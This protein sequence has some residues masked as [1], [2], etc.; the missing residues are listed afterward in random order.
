M[1]GPRHTRLRERSRVSPVGPHFA[2][3]LP[4]TSAQNSDRHLRRRLN[5][6]ARRRPVPQ[7]L[8]EPPRLRPYPALDQLSVL[9]QDAD[10]AVLRVD[11]NVNMVMVVMATLVTGAFGCIGAWVVRGLLAA[12]DRPVVPRTS[13]AE[14]V[15]RTLEALG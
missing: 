11:V 15:R 8:A 3:A 2:A 6:D 7:H 4:V 9:G 5:H 1:V 10:L 12:G 14:G 13:F